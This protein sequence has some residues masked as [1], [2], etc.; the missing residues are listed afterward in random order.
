MSSP[1]PHGLRQVP[2]SLTKAVSVQTVFFPT[3][4]NGTDC[5]PP[6]RNPVLAIDERAEIS[7]LLLTNPDG[8]AGSLDYLH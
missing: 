1:N 5:S 8:G 4:T 3:E 2:I 6:R 7:G